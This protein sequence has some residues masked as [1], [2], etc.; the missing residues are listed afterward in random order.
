M[1]SLLHELILLVIFIGFLSI[2]NL[3]VTTEIP[4]L[5]EVDLVE[6]A[7]YGDLFFFFELES[8]S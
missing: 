1:V 5:H 4:K 6:A 2:L 3:V 8:F 7:F